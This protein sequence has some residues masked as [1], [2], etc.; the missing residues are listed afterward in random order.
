[1]R[2]G[3]MTGSLIDHLMS[4]KQRMRNFWLTLLG[5]ALQWLGSWWSGRS[6]AST[7]SA[8]EDLT[9]SP[10]LDKLPCAL[11]PGYLVATAPGICC[12][13]PANKTEQTTPQEKC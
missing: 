9:A 3:C 11:T 8:S 7:S 4:A 12:W 5:S 1:M 13:I 10:G 6:L 2:P